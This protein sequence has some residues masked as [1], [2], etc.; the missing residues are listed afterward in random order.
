MVPVYM[1]V[2]VGV[3]RMGGCVGVYV[4]KAFRESTTD[5]NGIVVLASF[6][7]VTPAT[8]LIFNVQPIAGGGGY[9]DGVMLFQRGTV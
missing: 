1:C 8:Y 3:W 9:Q 5:Y 6:S 4:I 2:F 7:S